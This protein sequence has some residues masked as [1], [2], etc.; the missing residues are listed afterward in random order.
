M[1]VVLL[2]SSIRGTRKSCADLA[3]GGNSGVVLRTKKPYSGA[4]IG[5]F[6]K[7]AARNEKL[8][9]LVHTVT[10]VLATSSS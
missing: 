9:D 2:V 4:R 10:I 5:P 8:P 3:E 6:S 1:E 7:S